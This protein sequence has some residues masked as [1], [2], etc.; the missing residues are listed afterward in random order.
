MRFVLIT[1]A[2]LFAGHAQS[3]NFWVCGSDDDPRSVFVS[4]PEKGAA[5]VQVG[6]EGNKLATFEEQVD[7]DGYRSLR[8]NFNDYNSSLM[9]NTSLKKKKKLKKG[10][11]NAVIGY[12]YDFSSVEDGELAT[13]LTFICIPRVDG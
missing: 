8:F 11:N 5:A 13:G 12:L 1:T 3:D 10:E 6:G 4:L 2:L 9:L 7:E